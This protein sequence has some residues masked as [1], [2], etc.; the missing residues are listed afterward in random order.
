[1][2]AANKRLKTICVTVVWFLQMNAVGMAAGPANPLCQPGDILKLTDDLVYT[3]STNEGA[4]NC[5]FN[6]V[7]SGV[8]AHD[9]IK[10]CNE[11]I[12]DNVNGAGSRYENC[13]DWMCGWLGDHN[14]HPACA[15]RP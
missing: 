7:H 5:F 6:Q 4:R 15:G 8:N 2:I 12:R 11:H 3:T 13:D 9:A 10:N 1:M 14:F